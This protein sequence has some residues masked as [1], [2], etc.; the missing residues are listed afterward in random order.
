MQQLVVRELRRRY[1]V[2]FV[3][4]APKQLHYNE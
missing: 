1:V 3:D 4:K 2:R